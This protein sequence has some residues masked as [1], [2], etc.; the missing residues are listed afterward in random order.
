MTQIGTDGGL[1]AKPVELPFLHQI[2]TKDD[3]P[4]EP[5]PQSQGLILAPAERADLIVNFTGYEG[6]HLRLINVAIAPFQNKFLDLADI[7]A[8]RTDALAPARLTE[9]QVMEFRVGAAVVADRFELPAT[10]SDFGRWHHPTGAET[11]A[12]GDFPAKHEHRLIALVESKE[13]KMLN[14]LEMLAVDPLEAIDLNRH[15]TILELREDQSTPVDPDRPTYYRVGAKHFLDTVNFEA[16]LGGYELWKILNLTG[17]THPFHI[18]LVQ[19]QILSRRVLRHRRCG[20]RLGK[21]NAQPAC[22]D[23]VDRRWTSAANQSGRS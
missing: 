17:D 3:V 2:V 5:L 20:C 18:H 16:D 15:E 19:C 1:L 23:E 12:T 21:G 7:L 14:L 6:K 11:A 8:K 10:L 22:E 13:T 9:P 4:V